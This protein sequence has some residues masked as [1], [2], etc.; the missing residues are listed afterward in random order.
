MRCHLVLT[1]IISNALYSHI[2]HTQIMQS[3]ALGWAYRAWRREWRGRGKEFVSTTLLVSHYE[4]V[5]M[6]ALDCW[7]SRV[8]IK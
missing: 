3:E 4:R 2:Y 1:K 8:A 6:A 5:F 7:C